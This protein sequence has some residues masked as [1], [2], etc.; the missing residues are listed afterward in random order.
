MNNK[1][2][3]HKEIAGC[4]KLEEF[5]HGTTKEHVSDFYWRK[6]E[7]TRRVRPENLCIKCTGISFRAVLQWLTLSS[8][9]FLSRRDGE[10][11]IIHFVYCPP[12]RN[13]NSDPGDYS[14]TLKPLFVIGSSI[15]Q[16]FF[17]QG[18]E[19][20]ISPFRS[21]IK[22]D[23]SQWFKNWGFRYWRSMFS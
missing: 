7:T 19:A 14:Q 5:S 22:C 17:L 20:L 12:L 10:N 11:G 16:Q 8:S 6:I 4:D 9:G 21:V 2:Y 1:V 23:S 18:K 3:I 13:T 15:W